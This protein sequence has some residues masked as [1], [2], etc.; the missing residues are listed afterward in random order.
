MKIKTLSIFSG[1][2]AFEEALKKLNI[3]KENFK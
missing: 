1:L 3:E 2:G